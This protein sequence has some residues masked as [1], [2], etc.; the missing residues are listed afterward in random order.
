MIRNKYNA[1]MGRNSRASSGDRNGRMPVSI[2]PQAA[3]STQGSHHSLGKESKLSFLSLRSRIKNYLGI[4]EVEAPKVGLAWVTRFLFQIG[5]VVAW[6]IVTALWV[7]NFGIANLLWLFLFDAG[8]CALGTVLAGIFLPRVGLRPFLLFATGGAVVLLLSSLFFA[9]QSILFFALVILA[10][11]F[12]CT[13]LNIAL[14]RLH[15]TFFSPSEAQRF[16]P[17]VESAVT[18]GA[19]TGAG[20]T[21]AALSSLSPQFVLVVWVSALIALGFTIWRIPQKLHIIPAFF[22]VSE[23]KVSA[24]PLVEALHGLRKTK[25]LRHLAGVLILQAAVFTI[26]EFQFTQNVQSSVEHGKPEVHSVTSENLQASIFSDMRENVGEISHEIKEEV[27]YV[28]SHLVMHKT[29]A[30]ALGMFHLIFAVLALLVQFCTPAIIRSLGVVG[31]MMAYAVILFVGIAGLALGY[32]S[33]NFLRLIQHGTG[34]IGET[35]Y[36]ISFY[37]IFSHSRESVRLFF[38]GILKPLGM[39]AGVFILL[40]FSPLTVLTILGTMAAILVIICVPM[41]QSFTRLSQENLDETE[42]VEGMIHSIEVLA[43]RGHDKAEEILSEKLRNREEHSI[44]REKIIATISQIGAPDSVHTYLAILR[45]ESEPL[46][47]KIQILDSLLQIHIPESYWGR[48]TFTRYHLLE[49]LKN[50]FHTMQ[51]THIRKLIVMNLFQHLPKNEIAPFFLEEMNGTNEKVQAVF[52]RSCRMFEDP[53]ITFYIHEYLNHRNPRIR[54]H[55]VIA[56]WKFEKSHTELRKVLLNLLESD[57]AQ[58]QIA[59]LYALGEVGDT[60]S[61]L[62]IEDFAD[63]HDAKLRL[64]ALLALAK[65]RDERAIQ[66]LLEIL[67]GDD[68]HLS[69]DAFSMLSRVPDSIRSKIRKHIQREVSQKV[70]EILQDKEKPEDL[71]EERW[72]YLSWLYRMAGRFDDLVAM[73]QCGK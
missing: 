56:L 21:I 72:N 41:R 63:H 20:L 31:S 23:E 5:F 60:D 39:A 18:I 10:K 17:V 33:I 49:T 15:E 59:A 27:A 6:T 9:A 54:S 8:L 2:P 24:H 28:S 11:D 61:R 55:A 36:H 68:F 46:E 19:V 57:D 14:Y 34:S 62:Q 69:R 3:D 65:L 26:I 37:S 53:E 12:F 32:G 16:M 35:P 44:V 29:L 66:G 25:F 58:S 38:E 7:E 13:Q 47:T 71:S 70:F 1:F 40:S 64:H 43:Q 30:H 45:D 51:H 67:F 48:H 50:M 4:S 52:L 22:R 73:E 42:N